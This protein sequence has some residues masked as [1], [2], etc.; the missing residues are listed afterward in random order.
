MCYGYC[1]NLLRSHSVWARGLKFL[2]LKYIKKYKIVALCMSAWIEIP[3]MAHDD[4]VDSSRTLY[5]C[6]E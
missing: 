5:E 6:M 4:N 3:N 2:Q 1:N